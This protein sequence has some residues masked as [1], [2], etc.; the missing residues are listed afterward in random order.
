MAVTSL[1]ASAASSIEARRPRAGRPA[2]GRSGCR[3]GRRPAAGGGGH[4]TSN[5]SAAERDH[6]PGRGRRCSRRAASAPRSARWTGDGQP[7]PPSTTS[8]GAERARS[9]RRRALVVGLGV[10]QH[11]RV[12]PL[13]AGLLQACRI[14]PSGGPVSTSTACRRAGSASRRPG[15]RRGTRRRARR[16]R[17][18]GAAPCRGARSDERA[19]ATRRAAARPR[20]AGAA[21]S[22]ARRRP[23]RAAAPAPHGRRRSRP[24]SAAQ[25]AAITAGD[26]VDR[27]DRERRAPRSCA[28]PTGRRR[29]AARSA[30]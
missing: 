28:R 6:L 30:R 14:G 18:R 7:A 29:A 2:R 24:A 22:P 27:H 12:Q 21:A 26:A 13:D 23:R 17:R 10:G 19:A 15:R 16:G 11:Q 1:S 4:R 20:A 3:S 9:P 5:R 25:P 8:R